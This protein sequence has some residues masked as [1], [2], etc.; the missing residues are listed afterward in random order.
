M[1]PVRRSTEDL[2]RSSI[3]Q[4]CKRAGQTGRDHSARTAAGG[5]SPLIPS[6]LLYQLGS[7]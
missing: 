6:L 1:Y 3:M 7:A 2:V 5:G 4:L